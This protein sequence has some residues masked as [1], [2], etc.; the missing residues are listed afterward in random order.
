MGWGD[1]WTKRGL[2]NIASNHDVRPLSAFW[3]KRTK[4][5][6]IWTR[7]GDLIVLKY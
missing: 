1:L 4:I 3:I 7:V 2:K 5:I 6:G